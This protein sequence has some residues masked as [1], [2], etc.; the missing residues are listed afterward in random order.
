MSAAVETVRDPTAHERAARL[1]LVGL[2]VNMSLAGMKLIAG[3]VGH[4]YALIADAVESMADLLGSVVIW[5]G[6][7]IGARPADEDHPYGHGKAESLAALVVAGMVLAAGIAVA[8][9]AIDVLITPVRAPAPWTLIVLGVVLVSKE[10][11]FRVVRRAARATG[12][13]AVHTDA[14]HHRTD[15]ITSLA[16]AIGIGLSVFAGWTRADGVAALLGGLLIV[17]NGVALARRPLHELM[18]REPDGLTG[19][20]SEIASRV[21]GVELVQQCKARQ[22]GT[23][24]FIDMHVWVDG[25]M[26]VRESHALAHAVKDAVRGQ[27]PQIADV[28]IHIEPADRARL[29]GLGRGTSEAS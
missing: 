8:V 26:S 29:A 28:L 11:M 7:K 3:V 9:K 15:A 12:S 16:A 21:P 18:D 5:G 20:A 17:G 27:L 4:S 10:T 14:W 2:G 24:S 13:S 23:T 1:A 25:A 19:R 6:L 22:S